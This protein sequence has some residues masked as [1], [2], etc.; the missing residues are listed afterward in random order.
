MGRVKKVEI[1]ILGGVTDWTGGVGGWSVM[2]RTKSGIFHLFNPSQ[3]VTGVF[4]AKQT[5]KNIKS[6]KLKS[7]FSKSMDIVHVMENFVKPIIPEYM[8][9][10]PTLDELIKLVA[11]SILDAKGSDQTQ[12]YCL[13]YNKVSFNGGLAIRPKKCSI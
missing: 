3:R 11:P 5:R 13:N 6:K 4:R 12:L 7:V 9:P 1:S 8:D 2:V 10:A